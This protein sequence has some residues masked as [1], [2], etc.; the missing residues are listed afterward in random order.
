MR[1][2]TLSL[3][4]AGVFLTG[5]NNASAQAVEQGNFLIDAY[6]GFPNLYTAV[7]KAAYVTSGTEENL[8]VRG[9]GPMGLRGEYLV[10]DKIGIGLD[11]GFNNTKI[12]YT[13]SMNVYDNL[14]GVSLP[15]DY[16]YEFTTKKLGVL[17][18]FNYHF[19]ELDQIDAY[20]VLGAG[21]GNRS[22]NFKSSNPD[23]TPQNLNSIIPIA[24]KIGIGA[25]Y[26]FT[27]SIGANIALGLG[28]GGIINVGLSAKF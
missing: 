4:V 5:T 20:F 7:F 24:S 26:F 17:A 2:I 10:G 11:I 13:E 18:T 8:K 1:K 12:S 28:Q 14:A 23:Y 6:Y 22:F 27:E 19:L 15:I 25:R 21:Y 9:I 3:F 16:T